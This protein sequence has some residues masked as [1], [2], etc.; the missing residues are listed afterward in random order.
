MSSP[1]NWAYEK[2]LRDIRPWGTGHTWGSRL[3]CTLLNTLTIGD[4]PAMAETINDTLEYLYVP[5][6]PDKVAEVLEQG[7]T[8]DSNVPIMLVNRDIYAIG[9]INMTGGVRLNGVTE[10]EF[11]GKSI[12]APAFD[13]FNT[14]VAIKVRIADLDSSLLDMSSEDF[15]SSFYPGDIKCFTY[16]G[17]IPL[18][19]IVGHIEHKLSSADI[20][21][22]P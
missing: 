9:F 1:P 7:I 16:A 20:P 10:F 8:S 12:T 6:W 4:K 5:T 14:G 22:K 18:S 19:A 3:A 2:N 21:M 13:K 11:E 17:S 15:S